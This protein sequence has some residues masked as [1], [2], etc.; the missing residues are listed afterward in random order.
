MFNSGGK[1]KKDCFCSLCQDKGVLMSGGAYAGGG[2]FS[3]ACRALEKGEKYITKKPLK[4]R[5]VEPDGDSSEIE[6]AHAEII[7]QSFKIAFLEMF[8][9]VDD[10]MIKKL[11]RKKAVLENWLMVFVLIMSVQL[12]LILALLNINDIFPF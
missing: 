6:A 3:C 2:I 5:M 11:C 12:G 9:K 7:S 8:K 1:L 10:E 4:M